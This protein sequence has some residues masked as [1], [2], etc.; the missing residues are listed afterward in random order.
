MIAALQ[1]RRLADAYAGVSSEIDPSP[2]GFSHRVTCEVPDGGTA[3]SN[4][5]WRLR[6]WAPENSA[7]GLGD[8]ID[9]GERA[10]GGQG[11]AIA[12][13]PSPHR[14]ELFSGSD[15]IGAT[16]DSEGSASPTSLRALRSGVR[17][18]T[19]MLRPAG[20]PHPFSPC[21][22]R[23]SASSA[24]GR[25]AHDEPGGRAAAVCR[26]APLA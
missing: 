17:G 8:V 25:P 3:R 14:D 24:L 26:P 20:R 2:G 7:D 10:G 4:R 13:R 12:E 6:E 21:R 1:A 19:R 16:R 11:A 22:I 18:T 9:V 15:G 23:P 5:P